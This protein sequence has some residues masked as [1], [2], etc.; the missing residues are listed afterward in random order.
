MIEIVPEVGQQAVVQAFELPALYFG[1]QAVA[2][3]LLSAGEN[4][5]AYFQG[6]GGAFE[7]ELTLILGLPFDQLF[8]T[9]LELVPRPLF[10][11]SIKRFSGVYFG[12][13]LGFSLA[14]GVLVDAIDLIL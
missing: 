4:G 7:L 8:Q 11:F 12:F 5:K 9:Y 2:L 14:E 3:L 10:Q 1:P 6:H 13:L